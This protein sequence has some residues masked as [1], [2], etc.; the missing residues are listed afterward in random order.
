VTNF[1]SAARSAFV[2]RRKPA[3]DL[4]PVPL[5]GDLWLLGL[6]CGHVIFSSCDG[7]WAACLACSKNDVV[8]A[9]L[10]VSRAHT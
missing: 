7:A 10:K 1:S 9:S 8:M 6:F 5:Y 3:A 4:L 2:L